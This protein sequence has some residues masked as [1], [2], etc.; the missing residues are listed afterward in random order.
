M[1]LI[2]LIWDT[3]FGFFIQTHH[4][5][6]TWLQNAADNGFV[7]S[8]GSLIGTIVWCV[9]FCGSAMAAM[10]IAEIK[11]R[12]RIGHGAL[13]LICPIIYPVVLYFVIPSAVKKEIDEDAFEK[14]LLGDV[15]P[16]SDL[17]SIAKADK[18][19]G[20]NIIPD[21]DLL[22]QQ[23]FTRTAK[24]E[25][26]KLR[27]PFI[28][29]LDD[30]QILEIEC[31]VE[32]LPPAVAVQIG[33]GEKAKTIRLPYAKIKK[34]MLKSQ[35][36]SDAEAPDEEYEEDAEVEESYVNEEGE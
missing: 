10:T 33:D 6:A 36:L 26:G 13:G 30:D 5:F 25:M 8:K 3:L 21:A 24:D 9:I 28:L 16:D 18:K 32:A 11:F 19:G 29:E 23:Y 17:K 7:I 4:Y 35:W 20:L 22:D 12:N 1:E 15:I 14:E 27:G 34:C 2:G 31:I